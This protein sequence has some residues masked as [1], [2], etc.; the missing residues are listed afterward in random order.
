MSRFAKFHLPAILY[1]AL[2]IVLSS[3]PDLGET[4]LEILTYDK[5]IHFFEYAI[6]AIL[7]FRSFTHMSDRVNDRHTVYLSVLFVVL[8]ALL[9]EFYQ[10]FIPGRQPDPM[11]LLFDV[12]GASTII[13]YL[14]IRQRSHRKQNAAG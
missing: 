7:I 13:I 9:D 1:A 4:Q 11:D 12:V 6:F 5:A 3:I 2:I 8:F 14:Y 10:S